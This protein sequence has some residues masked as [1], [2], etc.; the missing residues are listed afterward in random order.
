MVFDDG[1][2]APFSSLLAGTG[3]VL[4]ENNYVYDSEESNMNHT[5][6]SGSQNMYISQYYNRDDWHYNHD[7]KPNV[8]VLHKTITLDNSDEQPPD[9][10]F[11][12]L[13]HIDNF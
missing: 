9:G 1:T 7:I 10:K 8:E 13:S 5:E 2:V 4:K 11:C 3:I 6:A 12:E